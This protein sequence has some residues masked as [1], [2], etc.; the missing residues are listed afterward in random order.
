MAGLSSQAEPSGSMGAR[1]GISRHELTLS[2]PG[3]SPIWHLLCG[4]VV[5]VGS[6]QGTSRARPCFLTLTTAC[7][8]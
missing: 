2:P 3:P 4:C 1:S 5:L 8:Y 7:W 6:C